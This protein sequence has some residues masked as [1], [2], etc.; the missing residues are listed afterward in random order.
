MAPESPPDCG[1][2]DDSSAGEYVTADDG[3]E[4][5][6]ETQGKSSGTSP[7]KQTNSLEPLIEPRRHA[8]VH[9]ALCSLAVD[10]LIH[11]IEQ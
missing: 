7:P 4:A 8:T 11:F 2:G 1:G 10:L 6:I 5:D 9:P 3:Y